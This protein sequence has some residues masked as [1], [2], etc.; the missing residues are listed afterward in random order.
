MEQ[1]IKSYADRLIR[2]AAEEAVSHGRKT[3]TKDDAEAASKPE[4]AQERAWEI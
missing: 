2:R 4:D 1:D 3:I